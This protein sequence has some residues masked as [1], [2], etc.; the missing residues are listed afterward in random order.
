MNGPFALVAERRR[1]AG[2]GAKPVRVLEITVWAVDR[3]Q[4]VRATRR[5]HPD[6]GAVPLVAGIVGIQTPDAYR[7]GVHARGEIGDAEMHRLEA[8]TRLRNRLDVRHS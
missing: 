4:P 5:D 7:A 1:P 2:R 3:A 8:A 6:Q